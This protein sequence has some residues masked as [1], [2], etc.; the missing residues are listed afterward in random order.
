MSKGI[1]KKNLVSNQGK[2]YHCTD[3]EKYLENAVQPRL[4]GNFTKPFL[5]LAKIV[6]SNVKVSERF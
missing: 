3:A 1:Q 6:I 4:E 5:Q 2:I